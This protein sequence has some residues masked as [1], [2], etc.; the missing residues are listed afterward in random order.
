MT[1]GIGSGKSTVASIFSDLGIS[2]FD[3]DQ[4]ARTITSSDQGYVGE[5]VKRFGNR[6]LFP[7]GTVN[8]QV[9]RSI[10]FSDTK[11][12]SFIE[13]QLHPRIKELL[14]NYSRKAVS[15]YAIVVVPLLFEKKFADIVDRTICIDLPENL[16][17]IRTMERDNTTEESV[18][19]IVDCQ[20]SRMERRVL[21]DDLLYNP[22]GISEKKRIVLIFHN[23]YLNLAGAL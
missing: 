9:L 19:K 6:I 3:A 16:Q 5:L 17:I 7:D 1:G 14:R 18:K 2:V 4:I 8:R 23:L 12:L 20:L 22:E 13:A 15:P 21:A 11:A 10:V